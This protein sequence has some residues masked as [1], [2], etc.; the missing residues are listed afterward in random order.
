M[1]RKFLGIDEP[2]TG[3][4]QP[5]PDAAT[6]AAPAGSAAETATVRQI[7][8]RLE[9]LPP[10][11]A[12]YLACFAYVMSRAAQADLTVSDDET[13]VMERFAAEYGG[14]D[15]SQAVLVVGM[16]KLSA[17]AYGAT[18]DYV[19]TREFKKISTME[20]RVQLIRCCFAITATDKT[21]NANEASVVNE[22]AKELDIERSDLNAVRDEF[23]EQL[24]S[25]Q[26]L[27]K[28]TGA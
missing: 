20:Q 23:H 26:A 19:V 25:V 13:A 2:T 16:A 10:D 6:A 4:A 5:A 3:A 1:L 22:I 27:R 15:E 12:R 11:E 7:V 24:S 18:E 14:L 9:S 8:G 17:V 21:I 28:A